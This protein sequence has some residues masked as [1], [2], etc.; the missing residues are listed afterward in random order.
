[1]L[2]EKNIKKIDKVKMTNLIQ[3]CITGAKFVGPKITRKQKT[4]RMMA[5]GFQ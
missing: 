1:M 4:V 3:F 2:C 5:T